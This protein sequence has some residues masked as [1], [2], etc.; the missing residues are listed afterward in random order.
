MLPDQRPHIAKT[1][2][3]IQRN[4]LVPCP[5]AMKDA[6]ASRIRG[7]KRSLRADVVL[8]WLVVLALSIGLGWL[9]VYQLGWRSN[10]LGFLRKAL[11]A[12]A[13]FALYSLLV[14]A[15]FGL[16]AAPLMFLGREYKKRAGQAGDTGTGS[17]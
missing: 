4:A 10:V 15:G 11:S 3:C 5:L 2:E 14:G 9:M 6:R 17:L 8:L 7:L 1:N 12:E 16:A 13:S